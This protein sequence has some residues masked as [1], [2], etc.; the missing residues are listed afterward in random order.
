M[1]LKKGFLRLTIT[2][3]I[4]LGIF[5][6]VGIM[7]APPS[8]V[9]PETVNFRSKYRLASTP[10]EKYL[11]SFIYLDDYSLTKKLASLYP[12]YSD[13]PGKV[14]RA[15]TTR[16]IGFLGLPYVVY[17]LGFFVIRPSILFIIKGFKG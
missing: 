6:T 17:L 1:N 7:L 2:I 13:L 15:Y 11:Q 16:I 4:A 14:I 3:S 12:E 9:I 10:E 5:S 8:N